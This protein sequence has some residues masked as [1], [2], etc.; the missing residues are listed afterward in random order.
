MKATLTFFL[1]DPH[2]REQYHAATQAVDW[3]LAMGKLD[4][5]LRRLIRYTGQRG[6]YR[7]ARDMLW[8]ILDRYG[9]D[10]EVLS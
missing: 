7:L 9:L 6:S 3:I 5:E 1:D 8:E 2:D 4:E 10:L